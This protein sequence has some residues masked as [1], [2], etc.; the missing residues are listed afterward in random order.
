M[1]VGGICSDY[2]LYSLSDALGPPMREHKGRTQEHG[3]KDI[4]T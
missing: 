4:G 1:G 3:I 2:I